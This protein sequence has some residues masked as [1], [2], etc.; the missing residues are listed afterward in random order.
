MFRRRLTPNAGI[1]RW[2]GSD[3]SITGSPNTKIGDAVR[4]RKDARN[5][6]SPDGGHSNCSCACAR[7]SRSLKIRDFLVA[8]FGFSFRSRPWTRVAR[9]TTVEIQPTIS[10]QPRFHGATLRL[11][12]SAMPSP[13]LTSCSG[14]TTQHGSIPWRIWGT[15]WIICCSTTIRQPI[16]QAQAPPYPPGAGVMTCVMG[17]VPCI[18]P[19][20]GV[21]FD[22]L[23]SV[24]LQPLSV[25]S[26]WSCVSHVLL[27]RLTGSSYC[28]VPSHVHLSIQGLAIGGIWGIREG[29]RRPLAV[30]NTRLRINSVLN[31]VTRRGTFIGNSAGVL[32]LSLLPSPVKIP[33]D[34]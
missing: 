17:P 7:Q 21:S 4:S 8:E 20:R 11:L 32:G 27:F 5:G 34:H 31:S 24:P 28:S 14:P 22:L 9:R 12:S 1:P 2:T 10:K 3:E 18:S 13:R 6:P 15:N 25:P 26:P 23:D 16:C 29:A 33:R 30:S 19:V